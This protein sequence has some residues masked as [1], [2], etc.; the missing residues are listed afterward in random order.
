MSF[1]EYAPYRKVVD[2]MY[3]A[4]RR[5]YTAQESCGGFVRCEKAIEHRTE[6]L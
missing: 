6:E 3:G 5:I 1:N 4:V 2:D